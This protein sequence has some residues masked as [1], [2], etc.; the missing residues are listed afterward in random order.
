MTKEQKIDLGDV[1]TVDMA[2]TLYNEYRIATIVMD[3]R[4]VQME[5]EPTTGQVK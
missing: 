4:Y 2:Q 5:E 3:G 1:I